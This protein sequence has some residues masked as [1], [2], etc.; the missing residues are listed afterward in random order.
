MKTNYQKIKRRKTLY[1]DRVHYDIIEDRIVIIRW[2]TSCGGIINWFHFDGNK[3]WWEK[4]KINTKRYIEI[5][6]LPERY[7]DL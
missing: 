2:D 3:V 7:L 5:D 6:R 1:D 4:G